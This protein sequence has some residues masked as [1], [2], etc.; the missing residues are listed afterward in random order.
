MTEQEEFEF[1]LRLEREQGAAPALDFAAFP[2]ALGRQVLNAGAGLIRGAGSIGA[3]LLTPIDA[4]AR[5]LGVQNDFIGRTDR[6][7]AMDQALSGLG[8]DT[9]SLA[10]GVGKLGTE[11]AGTMGAGGVLARGASLLPGA[12]RA[13][14]VVDA[15]RSAGFTA[16]GLTGGAGVGARMLGGA[17][18]GG[19][20]AALVNP[21]DALTGAAIG[22]ALPP[23]LQ[24][25]G[26]TGRAIG[27]ALRS[28]Q[29]KGGAEIAK[30]LELK[31]AQAVRDAV[32]KLRGAQSLVPGSVPT[33]AQALQ[34][35]Q[36]GVLQRVMAD[37]K[38]GAALQ[39][40]L[41]AQNAA[42]MAALE[43]VAPTNPTGFAS[44]RQDMGEAIGRYA[45]P[46]RSAARANTSRL[47]GEVPQD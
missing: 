11:I 35:P 4:A 47:Y 27:G 44:A 25:L 1:R 28:P 16:G 10:F 42:R 30:A 40:Q 14:P 22:A 7:Q 12:A 39:E 18:T 38:G 41:A 17:V 45:I 20:S 9:D 5:A 43:A 37:S 34:T 33:A 6:R 46:A 3:T 19:A 2:K 36:A 23:A 26:A 21:D 29:K 32:A 24:G 31:D 8:A 13:A 15:I